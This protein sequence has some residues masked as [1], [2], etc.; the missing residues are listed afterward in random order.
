MPHRLLRRP[1]HQNLPL[2]SF[3]LFLWLAIA[4][5]AM[6]ARVAAADRDFDSVIANAQGQTVFFNAWGG[7]DKINAYIDWAGGQLS[8]RFGIKLVHVKLSDTG[9]A[10]SRILA[11]KAAGRDS[12]GSIDLLW[13]NGENFAAMKRYALLQPAP[14]V[15]GLP[16]WRYTDAVALP[17]LKLDFAEPTDGLESPWGR[18]QLVF[19]YDSN[20][21][22]Q[23]PR[24]ATELASYI[25]ANPGRFTYPLPP[26][27]VGLSFLKQ[28]LL[29]L[30]TDS[31]TLY[32]PVSDADF[33][34]VTA[35]LWA[36]LDDAGPQLWR[37]GRTYPA[38]YPALRQLLADGEI[39][40]AMAF[41][42]ADASA[43]IARGELRPSIRTYIHEG[44]TLA[45]V[46]FLAIPFNAAAPD[47]AR[48]VA[49]F[50]LSPE[51]QIR[52]ADPRIWG[53]PTVLAPH[54]LSAA[55]RTALDALPRGVATLGAADLARTLAEPHPSWM[56][57]IEAAWKR[58]YGAGN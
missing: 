29:E 21:T 20:I 56:P 3:C 23:P 33:D 54:R 47:A 51:A 7:D 9:A 5:T 14:W 55:D 38:N 32:A 44:G 58:R 12:G 16:N 6:P 49:N 43:A 37:G 40:I 15:E 17:A 2:L 35:P 13:V 24:N 46:H 42:P 41:N 25:K 1:D 34:K 19:A 52:K 22:P 30:T 27:F 53:D 28:L 10:V 36:W 39:D 45:N 8:D 57:A 26:D 48:V 50:M 31:A 11:E 4:I 18:A